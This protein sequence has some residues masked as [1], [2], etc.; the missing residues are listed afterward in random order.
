V[1]TVILQIE[2]KADEKQLKN[3]SKQLERGKK[4]F[5]DNIPFCKEENWTYIKMICFGDIVE[6]ICSG[7]NFTNIL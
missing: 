4:F 3:A 7:A 5:E 6:K 1:G 2:V